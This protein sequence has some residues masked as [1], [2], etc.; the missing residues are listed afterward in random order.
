M[1]EIQLTYCCDWKD[2]EKLV[3]SLIGKRSEDVEPPEDGDGPPPRMVCSRTDT[4]ATENG[5]VVVATF[6]PMTRE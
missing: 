3:R 2:R 5:A 6:V 1:A 4:T